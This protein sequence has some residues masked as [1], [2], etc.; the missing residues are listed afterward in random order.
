MD[1]KPQFL[2]GLFL[3]RSM[4][5]TPLEDMGEPTKGSGPAIIF[6]SGVED[7]NMEFPNAGEF[8]E[9]VFRF[10]APRPNVD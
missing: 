9:H 1:A 4:R 10:K 2:L 8:G 5:L 3:I 6:H 7:G